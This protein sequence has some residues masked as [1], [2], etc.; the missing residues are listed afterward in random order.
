MSAQGSAV[1]DHRRPDL[2]EIENPLRFINGDVDAS[3]RGLV[4]ADPEFFNPGGTV[5]RIRRIPLGDPGHGPFAIGPL[6]SAP[7]VLS[8]ELEVDAVH[9]GDGLMPN[10][11]VINEDRTINP[12][13][14]LVQGES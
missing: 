8:G 6:G 4:S 3:V 7:H 12:L 13:L 11:T 2:S 9:T 14:T 5:E 10:A 1:S